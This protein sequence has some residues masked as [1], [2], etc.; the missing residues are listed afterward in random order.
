MSFAADLRSRIQ[1][2]PDWILLDISDQE[3]RIRRRLAWKQLLFVIGATVFASLLR[4]RHLGTRSLWMDES[5]TAAITSLKWSSF[6]KLIFS[7]EMNM[8]AYYL[9]LRAFPFLHRSEFLLRLP[10]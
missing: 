8:S 1:R 6:W 2:V 10:S 4:I 3:V 5:A 7:R 9:L